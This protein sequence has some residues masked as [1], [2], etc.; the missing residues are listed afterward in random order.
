VSVVK[1][2]S[3]SSLKLYLTC[4]CAWEFRY[5]SGIKTPA[6]GP[7]M[8][9]SA[10]DTAATAHYR[11]K[12]R[13]HGLTLDEF[14]EAALTDH[15][16]RL[17]AEDVRLDVPENISR[18]MLERAARAYYQNIATKLTPRS[19]KD[20]QLYV[21]GKAGACKVVGY[22]DIVTNAGVVVDTKLMRQLPTDVES[23]LQLT[24]Y[25]WLTGAR[26]L[27][28]AVAQPTVPN[29]AAQLLFTERTDADCEQIALLYERAWCAIEAG[30]AV[31]ASPESGAC[32]WCDFTDRCEFGG[33]R[34]PRA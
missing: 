26:S 10:L 15:G 30:I 2:L 14:V 29:G 11:G 17:A 19:H 1:H 21:E 3:A 7:M 33:H 34:S 23:N 24:T 25:A 18:A 31:P 12:A 28:L 4:G 5:V 32:R 16:A 27:A 22:V 8:R 20:V 9:G 6:S 13:G